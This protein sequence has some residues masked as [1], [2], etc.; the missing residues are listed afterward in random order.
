MPPASMARHVSRVGEP[1]LG[2]L[3][4]IRVFIRFPAFR[5]CN[6][7]C[8]A[9]EFPARFFHAIYRFKLSLSKTDGEANPKYKPQTH[10]PM[11]ANLF[12][13]SALLACLA[14]GLVLSSCKKDDDDDDDPPTTKYQSVQDNSTADG[15]YSRAYNQINKASYQASGSKAAMDTI[16]GCPTLY[17]TGGMSY[18]KTVTLDFGSSCLCDDGVTRYGRIVSV[19]SAPYLDSGSVVTSTFDNYHEIINNIDY[20]ATG[21]QIITNLGTNS[22]SHPVYAVD[23][24]NA[25]V[26]STYGTISYTSQR[27]NE[28]A[29]GYDTWMN[30]WDD[31]YFVT[32][33]A[34][35]TDIN[36]DAF[37]VN[38]TQA[39][40]V[41]IGCYF[42][43][44][45]RLDLLN[46]GYTTITVDY[47][48]GTC[49]NII[50][51]IINGVTYT[52]VIQ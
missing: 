9:G 47:G 35:G 13:R 28:W 2:K 7:I 25:S 18:P 24:Q 20:Q 5:D 6:Y 1:V 49:D 46:P 34:D 11:K 22:Q 30:P 42:I 43:K 3:H 4:K 39:L 21:T 32:G 14:C 48:D 29:A 45:G 12:F 50:Y 8:P 10:T 33:S 26:I 41:Q 17:I 40:E 15:V 16:T 44:S 37:S 23:V 51:V 27:E 19:I 38:I 52:I 36:G 31:V